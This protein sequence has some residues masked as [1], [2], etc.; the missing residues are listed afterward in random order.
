[1]CGICGIIGNL[2]ADNTHR[3]RRMMDRMNHRGPDGSGLWQSEDG[4]VTLG[5]V[6]LAIVDTSDAGAQPMHH[7]A[8]LHSVV[9]GEIY[10]YL[11]LRRELEKTASFMS[12]CDSEVVLHGHAADGIDFVSRLNGM[13]ALALSDER[14]GTVI[15]ARDRLGIKPLYYTVYKGELLFAS[16]LKALFGAIDAAEW[17]IDRQGLTEYMTYQSALGE[18]TLFSDIRQVLPGHTITINVRQPDKIDQEPYW[19]ARTDSDVAFVYQDAL[20]S[21]ETVFRQSVERHLLSDVEVASYLSAGFDSASV[22][23]EASELYGKS[24]GSPFTAY[25]GRFDRGN[26]WYDE[27]GP[28]A[29]LAGALGANHR[30]V[31]INSQSVVD[32]LDAIL[33]ALDEPRMGMGAFSQYM[34]AKEAARDYKV[35]LTGHGGDELFSGYPVYAYAER[36][37]SGIRR[38]S[39]L[40]HFGY[41]FLSDIQRK[42][43]REQ[44][45]GLPVLWSV[46]EQ[47]RMTGTEITSLQPW[48]QLE[49]WGAEAEN[50][51]DRILLTYLNAY[52][53]G[54]LV[55]EDKI[56]MAHS[57]ESRTPI[58][59]NEMIDLSL[60]IPASVKLNGGQLKSI[61]K[62]HAKSK[63]PP[64]YFDQ[65]KRGFPTPL[66]H[67]LRGDLAEFV[68]Q[69]LAG[70]GSYLSAIFKP[71][72]IE[73][74]LKSYKTSWRRHLRPLDEIQSH[75]MWQLLSLESWLRVWSEKYGVMLR[76]E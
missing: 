65:P 5:H 59:D 66:R 51:S 12:H 56:S 11:L 54:L 73:R 50:A 40:P 30:K 10:N 7:P 46:A 48:Q 68:N 31:D 63:L 55:V 17:K 74:I 58:L 62:A 39:E 15:L 22:F 3:V 29:E 8:G 2:P 35:I 18:N 53:P 25:T 13:F 24:V 57:L 64:T 72:E 1:M 67:W 4:S 36:G 71:N 43:K 52:L 45:H 20:E 27:T 34:V 75:Q 9:N 76:F 16:E 26:A 23:A 21:F 37:L 44:G 41:F 19:T 6:R 70:S 32:H 28:A 47:A 49:K 60:S 33:D 69:R 14:D 38:L 42:I 61:V